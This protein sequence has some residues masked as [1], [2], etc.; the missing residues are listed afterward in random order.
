[1]RP[2]LRALR[3]AD[4]PDRWRSVGFAVDE[5]GRTALGDVAVELGPD[6]AGAGVRAWSL[7][8]LGGEAAVDG[9]AA[10]AAPGGPVPPSGPHPNGVRAIDHLVVSTPDL[11]RTVA[12]LEAAGFELRRRREGEAYGRPVRQAFFRVGQPILEVVGPQEGRGEGPAAFFGLACTVDDLDATAALLGEHLGGAKDA[13]QPGRRIAT[14][15][16]SAGLTTA[17]AFMS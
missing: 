4:D 10:F 5:A 12:A 17:V 13:V 14:L 16:S 3:V 1:V 7:E 11:D 8:G 6:G 2:T 9:L 15:R